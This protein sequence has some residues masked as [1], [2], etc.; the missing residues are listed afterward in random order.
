VVMQDLGYEL[1]RIHIPRTRVNRDLFHRQFI[2][3]CDIASSYNSVTAISREELV[4]LR[5]TA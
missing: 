3:V 1:P 2:G 5:S 4:Y